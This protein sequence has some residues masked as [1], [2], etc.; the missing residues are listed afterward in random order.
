MNKST[1]SEWVSFESHTA[2]RG[3]EKEKKGTI[4]AFC[5]ISVV[6]LVYCFI[7]VGRL[8]PGT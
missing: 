5:F 7:S 6:L 4:W 3:E 8:S 2:K 1:S